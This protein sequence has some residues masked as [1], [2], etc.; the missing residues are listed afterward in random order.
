M[1]IA[2]L[3]ALAVPLEQGILANGALAGGRLRRPPAKTAL[4]LPHCSE[5][6]AGVQGLSPE[7]RIDPNSP[8]MCQPLRRPQKGLLPARSRAV[9]MAHMERVAAGHAPADAS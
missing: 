7:S 6:E 1:L 5:E 8:H 2:E 3:T 9:S 4:P